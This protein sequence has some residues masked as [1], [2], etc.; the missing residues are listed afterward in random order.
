M[1]RVKLRIAHRDTGRYSTRANYAIP[2]YD[3][4][5]SYMCVSALTCVFSLLRHPLSD[6]TD[7][8]NGTRENRGGTRPKLISVATFANEFLRAWQESAG[9]REEYFPAIWYTSIATSCR[10]RERRRERERDRKRE[11]KRG[12]YFRWRNFERATHVDDW[13]HSQIAHPQFILYT[14]LV[15]G[16]LSR[17][18]YARRIVLHDLWSDEREF[19]N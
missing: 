11:R 9:G 2:T 5:F 15:T 19:A 8:I 17:A 4:R 7:R 13:S 3:T 10:E 18:D 14:I 6:Q 16:V 12:R 1:F